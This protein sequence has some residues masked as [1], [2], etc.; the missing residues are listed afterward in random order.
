MARDILLIW[1]F[2]KSR[3]APKET[4]MIKSR[5][6]APDLD[7][8]SLGA[9]LADLTEEAAA[10]ILPLWKSNLAVDSKADESPVTE[11]DRRAETLI[12][13]R[14]A[15]WYP[16]VPVVSEEYSSQVGVPETVGS[17]FFLVDPLDGT[18]AFVRGDPHFTVHIGLIV[19]GEPVAGAVT[20]PAT[21]ESW[22]TGRGGAFKRDAVQRKPRRVVAR[23]WPVDDAV[24]L[25]SHT[26]K[27]E[28]RAELERE[29]GV[30]RS[31]AMDSSVK[32][33]RIAEGGADIY[34]RH[35]PTMEWDIAAAHAVLAAAGGRLAKP[36]GEAFSYGKAAEGFRNGPFV[37]R[38]A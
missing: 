16:D 32:L 2:G 20:A 6:N 27:P 11:A 26:M 23:T 21:G 7:H 34:P 19:D 37:A 30:A 36:D 14:L 10:L 35:G 8:P 33:C 5:E 18:K 9:F 3:L 29:L 31:E 22:F 24:V 15:R 17:M 4:A 12:L 13:M 1:L 25:I 28:A 38:G